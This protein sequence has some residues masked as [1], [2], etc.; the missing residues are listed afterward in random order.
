MIAILGAGLSGL[1]LGK[2]LKERGQDFVVLED[3]PVIGGLCRTVTK[4]DYSWDVGPHAFYSKKPETMK[5]YHDLPLEYRSMDRKVRVCHR[6]GARVYE[7]GYPFENGLVDL[8]LGSKLECVAGYCWASWTGGG[9]PYK[10]LREWIDQGLGGGIGRHF[11]IPYNHK[12]WNSPL[13]RVSMDLVSQ[14]IEPEKAWRV[15][16]QSLFGGGVGR[17]YQAKFIYPRGGAGALPES[18]SAGFRDRVRVNAGARALERRGAGWRVRCADGQTVDADAVV[19]TIPIPELLDALKDPALSAR[20]ADFVSNDTMLV[21][22]GLKPG[23][24][25]ARFDDCQWVFFA[26]P[27]VFYRISQMRAFWSDRPATLVA[28]ITRKDGEALSPDECVSRAIRDLRE[29]GMLASEDD[30]ALAQA[31][32]ERYTYPIPT[33]TMRAAREE[34]E[35]RLAAQS[36]F[37]LG[38]MGRWD[39][40]NTDGV[41]LHVDAFLSGR[42]A[43]LFPKA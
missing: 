14:K 20:R 19:S 34:V 18:V 31:Q 38:R 37:L 21:V 13:E 12:I 42:G 5:Y 22:I 11:M 40:M 32:L 27:E 33:V 39:Y 4:G 26:G 36:V 24:S 43:G 2:R 9:G 30:V 35:A 8:P 23:R 7:V 3:K 10:H 15:V 16:R 41:F 29:L 1:Q 6:E 17:A 25:F 28:E